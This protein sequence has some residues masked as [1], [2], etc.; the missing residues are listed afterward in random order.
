MQPRPYMPQRV[1]GIG[2]STSH[3]GGQRDTASIYGASIPVS[4]VLPRP[5]G[6]ASVRVV[7]RFGLNMN[8]TGKSAAAA[9]YGTVLA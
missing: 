7:R 2:F 3:H 1:S 4:G 6:L 5:S 8:K 9:T